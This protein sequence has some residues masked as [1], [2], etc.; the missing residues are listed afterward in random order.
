MLGHLIRLPLLELES[1]ALVAVI[2]IIRLIFMVLDA[3]EVA[4]HCLGI[5]GESDQCVD[6]GRFWDELEL[7][8]L[9]LLV[10]AV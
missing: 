7:P 3:D 5:E 10:S 4:V 9:S 8:G 2:L 6:S 1:Q